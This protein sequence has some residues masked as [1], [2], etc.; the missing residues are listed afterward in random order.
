MQYGILQC[1]QHCHPDHSAVACDPQAKAGVLS[2]AGTL[3][4]GSWCCPK[5]LGQLFFCPTSMVF[6]GRPGRFE[7]GY[8]SMQHSFASG[9]LDEGK[10]VMM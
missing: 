2:P 5:S 10:G 1:Y 4:L 7:L 6:A 9:T 3:R 8:A